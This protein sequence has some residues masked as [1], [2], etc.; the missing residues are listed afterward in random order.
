MVWGIICN[1]Y[2]QAKSQWIWQAIT[3]VYIEDEAFDLLFV[4][5]S[6]AMDYI[7]NCRFF[8]PPVSLLG[9]PNKFYI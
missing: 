7:A 4:H 2:S 5:C 3:S 8:V 1:F 6:E 9:V